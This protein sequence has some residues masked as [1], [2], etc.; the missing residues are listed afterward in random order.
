M[1]SV[2]N[3]TKQASLSDCH[4]T[5]LISRTTGS[6]CNL[7]GEF[8]RAVG[9]SQPATVKTDR[10]QFNDGY[11]CRRHQPFR[12]G[13]RQTH[14]PRVQQRWL[15]PAEED[16]GLDHHT[17]DPDHTRGGRRPPGSH[18]VILRPSPE[19]S[20]KTYTSPEADASRFWSTQP[21]PGLRGGTT[22]RPDVTASIT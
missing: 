6:E 12:G 19:D 2:L 17:R 20:T 18:P 7:P 11:R 3:T 14:G 21:V 15:P 16:S 10:H 1:I 5:G 13:R 9:T 22:G 8:C 4:S